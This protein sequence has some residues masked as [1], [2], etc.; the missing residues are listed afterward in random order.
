M[1]PVLYAGLAGAAPVFTFDDEKDRHYVE[2]AWRHAEACAGRPTPI[3]RVEVRHG[4]VDMPDAINEGRAELFA[5]CVADCP[6]GWPG[7]VDGRCPP[8]GR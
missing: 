5:A 6:H 2:A 1:S 8:P 3:T 7:L 4:D